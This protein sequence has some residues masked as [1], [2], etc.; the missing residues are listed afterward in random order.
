MKNN[1]G[2][3]LIE[4]MIVVAILGILTAIAM[5]VYKDYIAKTYVT[6]GLGLAMS[7]K[8]AMTDYYASNGKFTYTNSNHNHLFDNNAAYGIAP[9]DTFAHNATE[10]VMIGN[11]WAPMG[12]TIDYSKKMLGL[13]EE[14]GTNAKP[15]IMLIASPMITDNQDVLGN[16]ANW[17]GGAIEWKCYFI[18]MPKRI[19]PSVC[20]ERTKDFVACDGF[21][22]KD[23]CK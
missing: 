21:G 19:A 23:A 6:E 11:W 18:F 5:P 3:T 22:D 2:F 20:E 7:A 12:I 4:L 10:R 16:G 8:V 15:R 14:T 9:A 1:H 17:K 13:G